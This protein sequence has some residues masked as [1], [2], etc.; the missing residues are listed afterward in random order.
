MS[1]LS[2]KLI[3]KAKY[4]AGDATNDDRLKNEGRA[5]EAKG[6]RKE[7]LTNAVDAVQT[8]STTRKKG[9]MS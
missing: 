5:E 7:K 6:T 3:G 1:G 8:K 9:L 2:D 4:I